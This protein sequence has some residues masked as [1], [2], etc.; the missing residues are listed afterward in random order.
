MIVCVYLPRFELVTAAGGPETLTDLL[1][2]RQ[3]HRMKLLITMLGVC[4]GLLGPVAAMAA[5]TTIAVLHGPSAVEAYGSVTAWSDYDAAAQSWHV[6]ISRDG[7]ISVPPIPTA[8]SA[9]EV[10]VGP[11]PSGA[12]MLA[13][14]SCTVECHVVVSSVEGTDPQTVPGSGGASHPTIWG[15]RV[16][17]VTDKAK[18]MISRLDGSERRVLAGAPARKCFYRGDETETTKPQ[19]VCAAPREP[20]VEG[21][22]L[23]RGQL[24]LI[25]TFIINDDIG[26]VGT[27]TE[28]RTEAAS[29]GPQ[30]LIAIIDVGEGDESWLGPSWSGGKLYFYED[31]MG[32]GFKVYRFNPAADAYSS[33]PAHTYLTGFSVIGGRAYE[34]TAGGHPTAGGGA[35]SYQDEP[36]VV[37]LS[38]PFTFKPTKRPVHV[39]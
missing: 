33:A 21:L 19:L 30:R 35:C 25:D 24:A 17:W 15:D 27:T 18:V 29:G 37:Q 12:P 6:V 2:S 3:A 26:S 4:L 5:P 20:S 34:A 8:K 13:Y 1:G 14:I 31:S 28:V 32:A 11:G 16:A 22:Q 39:P 38:E 7:A 23:Y 36:C 10:D 9:I